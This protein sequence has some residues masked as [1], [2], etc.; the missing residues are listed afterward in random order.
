[1]AFALRA[2]PAGGGDAVVQGWSEGLRVMLDN[3]LRNAA[4]HGRPPADAGRP[5][6]VALTVEATPAA[7]TLHVDDNG[8]GI[9]R[10]ERERVFERFT[11]G[12]TAAPGSGLG[13]A[14]VAQQAALHGGTVAVS[15]SPDGGARVTVMLP[16]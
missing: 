3:L 4:T 5:P 10:E 9:P 8:P 14:L 13:L 16:R 11:R 12:A 1:M 6:A 15:E 2:P 7:V